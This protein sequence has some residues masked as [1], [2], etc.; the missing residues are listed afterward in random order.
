MLQSYPYFAIAQKLNVPYGK[1]L[2][3]VEYIER[4]GIYDPIFERELYCHVENAVHA[5]AACDQTSHLSLAPLPHLTPH[6]QRELCSD[7][8]ASCGGTS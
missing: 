4:H 3:M 8:A 7:R 2:A 5:S 1:V 6:Y